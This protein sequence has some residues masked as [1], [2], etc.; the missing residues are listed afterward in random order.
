MSKI[1]QSNKN[2]IGNVVNNIPVT[3]IIPESNQTLVYN[4]RSQTELDY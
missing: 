4:E 1:E 3:S 2:I